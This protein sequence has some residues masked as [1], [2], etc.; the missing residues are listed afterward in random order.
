MD[1]ALIIINLYDDDDLTT[2]TYTKS[3]F[4]FDVKGYDTIY[5]RYIV[6]F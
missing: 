3:S 5:L 2:L 1:T 6:E 4:R